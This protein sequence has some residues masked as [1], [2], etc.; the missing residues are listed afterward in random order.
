[1]QLGFPA[2]PGLLIPQPD[3]H[4]QNGR[5]Q[6]RPD[7]PRTVVKLNGV[8]R[9]RKYENAKGSSNR[10]DVHPVCLAPLRDP[11]T[12][13]WI[14]ES[15]K[16]LD[17]GLSA[18]SDAFRCGVSIRGADS[19]LGKNEHGG[20]AALPCFDAIPWKGPADGCK[21]YI[22]LGNDLKPR[23]LAN[24]R[25][26]R[27]RLAAYLRGRGAEVWTIDI[28]PGADGS[29]GVLDDFLAAGGTIEELIALAVKFGE[30]ARTNTARINDPLVEGFISPPPVE[31]EIVLSEQFACEHAHDICHVGKT[32]EWMA[33][34]TARGLWLTDDKAP[35]TKVKALCRAIANQVM[36]TEESRSESR[37]AS[38]STP[39]SGAT[40]SPRSLAWRVPSLHWPSI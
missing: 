24:V 25:R 37:C 18:E 2:L 19:W 12:P 39:S 23:T 30:S 6:L 27:A 14:C 4:G 11:A 22:C 1:M 9:S 36:E 17:A 34:D 20:T 31:A 26:S 28:P 7:Q 33:F 35:A 16:K 15:S 8:V 32:D 5:Y 38:A 29:K 3:V 40:R 13:L 10:L 21:V